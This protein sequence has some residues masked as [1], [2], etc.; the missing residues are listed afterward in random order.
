M[1]YLI[2]HIDHYRIESTIADR[3]SNRDINLVR[4]Y[5]VIDEVCEHYV[6]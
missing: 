6:Q 2:E 5:T 1:I 4:P 3:S